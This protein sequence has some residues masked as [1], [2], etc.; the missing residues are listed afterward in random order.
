ME[1]GIKRSS[2]FVAPISWHHWSRKEGS[3]RL[4][5]QHWCRACAIPMCLSR[6]CPL[7]VIFDILQVSKHDLN[8]PVSCDLGTVSASYGPSTLS[9]ESQKSRSCPRPAGLV[10]LKW[11]AIDICKT[12]Q[13]HHLLLTCYFSPVAWLLAFYSCLFLSLCIYSSSSSQSRFTASWW[14]FVI[15]EVFILPLLI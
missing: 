11:I 15:F 2:F 8:Q 5:A 10:Q 13:V 12:R 6:L 9:A 7:W 3:A 14:W 1:N 4:C